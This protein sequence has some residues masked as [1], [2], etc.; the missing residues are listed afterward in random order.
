MAN[1]LLVNGLTDITLE[2]IAQNIINQTS[3]PII[4]DLSTGTQ[5]RLIIVNGI[6]EKQEI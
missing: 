2:A 5:Y 6:L 3:N 1:L 4:T